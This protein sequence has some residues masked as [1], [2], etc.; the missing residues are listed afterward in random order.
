M[1]AFDLRHCSHGNI[2]H[3]GTITWC[4]SHS[5]SMS[6][7]ECWTR[8]LCIPNSKGRIFFLNKFKPPG[9]CQVTNIGGKEKKRFWANFINLCQNLPPTTST[10]KISLLSPQQLLWFRIGF[11][12]EISL[13]L[14][15]LP[16]SDHSMWSLFLTAKEF[17]LL[18]KWKF[19]LM[20]WLIWTILLWF[21]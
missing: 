15:Q 11:E 2:T 6:L 1:W 14:L 9:G 5:G 13:V 7:T 10:V 4:L 17:L 21:F 12:G 18:K 16:K 20:N 3:I 8:A 19:F